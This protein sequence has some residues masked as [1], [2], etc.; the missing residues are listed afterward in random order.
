MSPKRAFAVVIAL[1]SL[2][3]NAETVTGLVTRV[4]DGDTLTLVDATRRQHTIRLV[5]ID[6]PEIGQD[7]GQQSRTR[8][9]ALAFNQQVFAQCT[10]RDAKRLAVCLVTVAGKD[11]GLEQL[12]GGMA[13]YRQ[14]GAQQTAR[15]RAGYEQAEFNAKIRR[16]GLWNSKN[17]TPPWEWRRGLPAE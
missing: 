6:A 2:A 9:S 7:F 4:A 1:W 11:I 14:E 17:P 13:W 16:L 10:V 8:L 12:R 3:V 15:E 5:D